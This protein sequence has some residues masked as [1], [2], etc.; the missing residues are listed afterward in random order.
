MLLFYVHKPIEMWNQRRTE[1]RRQSGKGK[2]V[3]N[4]AATSALMN[5][6]KVPFGFF[7]DITDS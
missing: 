7:H 2:K 3:E 5:K 4:L 1:M 6:K